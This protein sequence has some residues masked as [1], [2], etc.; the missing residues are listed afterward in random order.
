[1]L[2][3]HGVRLRGF[4]GTRGIADRFGLD[5]LVTAEVLHDYEK[6]GAVAFASFADLGGWSL[7]TTGRVHN[8]R[9]LAGELDAVGG[10]RELHEVHREF[11]PWNARLVQACTDWQ[12]R[13]VDGDPLAV[14]DHSEPARDARILEELTRVGNA[15]AP[16]TDR[17]TAVLERFDGY[18]SRYAVALE[19]A[20][21]GQTAWVDRS[22]VDSCHRVWFE[23]HEDLV[24]TLGIDRSTA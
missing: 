17:L 23:L 21:A 9:M 8:E 12:L 19:R 13:P 10:T 16:I 22:D 15:L 2:V 4:A 20:H 24:A 14:N 3:L 5:P 7:T 18:D 6:Q 11:L 1:M